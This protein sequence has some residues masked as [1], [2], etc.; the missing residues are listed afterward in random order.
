MLKIFFSL[1]KRTEKDGY[2]HKPFN[3]SITY[4]HFGY[5]RHELFVFYL[6]N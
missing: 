4:S 2:Y 6:L 1:Q 3:I 5:S